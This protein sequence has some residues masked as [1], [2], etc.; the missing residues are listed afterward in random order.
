M[1]RPAQR[2]PKRSL[3][4]PQKSHKGHFG[5]A[6]IV[7]GSGPGMAGAG[8]L[9]V[10]AAL[11]SGAGKTSWVTTRESYRAM[12]RA[13]PEAMS[14]VLPDVA[15]QKLTAAAI[16]RI[17]K[18]VLATATAVG[19]GPGLGRTSAARRLIHGLM[20]ASRVPLVL[21]ADALWALEGEPARLK[22]AKAPVILTPHEGELKRLFGKVLIEG[23]DASG[24]VA[25]RI[26]NQYHCV[27]VWKGPRT[28]VVSPGGKIFVN[29][30][31][32]PGL[33]KGGSG[34]VLTGMIAALAA[35]GFEPWTAACLGVRAHGLAADRAVRSSSVTSLLSSDL[36]AALPSVW[37]ELEKKD[38]LISTVCSKSIRR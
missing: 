26:A 36:L 33:A 11:R 10:A 8:C 18:K 7:A 16:A 22:R 21:D 5:H 4:R 38:D 17:L 12:G 2:L 28:R 15:F 31:G 9:A 24:S 25:K 29:S 32:N 19:A 14:L 37:S 34:D 20:A 30:T 23:E 27:L 35:Q 13:V 1:K 6:W 3:R